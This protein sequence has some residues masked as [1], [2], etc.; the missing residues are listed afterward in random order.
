MAD[1]GL[2]KTSIKQEK[3]AGAGFWCPLPGSISGNIA[4]FED[5]LDFPRVVFDPHNLPDMFSG[6]PVGEDSE[7]ESHGSCS[8]R[9]EALPEA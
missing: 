3:D 1:S 2:D 8:P 7:E 9:H 4:S 5:I 6:N